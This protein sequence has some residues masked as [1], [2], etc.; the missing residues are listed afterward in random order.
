MNQF[1]GQS[2]KSRWTL[3]EELS[4]YLLVNTQCLLLIPITL[5]YVLTVFIQHMKF[6][7]LKDGHRIDAKGTEAHEV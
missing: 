1:N 6:L 7:R 2:K 5:L 3:E 4:S